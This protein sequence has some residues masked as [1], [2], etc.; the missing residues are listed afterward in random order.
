[1]GKLTRQIWEEE[2]Y[3]IFLNNK[4]LKFLLWFKIKKLIHHLKQIRKNSNELK[5]KLIKHV[6]GKVNFISEFAI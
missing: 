6:Y 5:M 2:G 4:K 3:N 1:M